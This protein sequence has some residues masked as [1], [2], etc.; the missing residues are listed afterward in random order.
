MAAARKRQQKWRPHRDWGRG[1]ALL[2]CVVFAIL[3]AVPL[4]L[5]LLVRTTPV[6]A[7]AARETAA[8]LARTLKV[9]AHY[10]VAVQAWPMLIALENVVVDASDG[11]D[12]FLSV[13]RIAV[14]PRP[15]FVR[16]GRRPRTVSTDMGGP[17][18]RKVTDRRVCTP[19]CA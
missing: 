7:W 18:T 3:G 2:L 14:R 16:A 1:I 12:P 10:D 9:N 5:G 13:E 11:G 8:M 17:I 19:G 15:R 4:S 6:R